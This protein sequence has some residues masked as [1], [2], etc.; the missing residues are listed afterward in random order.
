MIEENKANRLAH[1]ALIQNAL[2]DIPNLILTMS[3]LAKSAK[4]KYDAYISEGFTPEQ[5]LFLC[6]DK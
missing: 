3:F 1:K 5:A 6:K 2:D 4:I